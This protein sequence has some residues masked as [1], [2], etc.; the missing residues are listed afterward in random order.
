MSKY[1]PDKWVIIKTNIGGLHYRVLASWYGGY[2]SS[3]SWRMSSG[4]ASIL[5]TDLN[6]EITNDSGSSY[7]C[8][9]TQIGMS[10]YTSTVFDNYK[11]MYKGDIFEIVPTKELQIMCSKYL[12]KIL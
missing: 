8:E 12:C 11:N 10:S 2:T 4:I 9:K 3:D 6:Y 5:E 1:V 7:I